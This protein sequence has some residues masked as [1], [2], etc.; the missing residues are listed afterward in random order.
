GRA[1]TTP[2]GRRS[3]CGKVRAVVIDP[4]VYRWV[5]EDLD[6]YARPV[7]VPKP[8]AVVP[9]RKR[10]VSPDSVQPSLGI[11]FQ[12]NG[13]RVVSFQ[14]LETLSGKRVAVEVNLHR[15]SPSR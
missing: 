11:L 6:V 1:C 4:A 3:P 8:L 14:R 15:A 9:S 10:G 2:L 7:N 12:L 5:G 13:I